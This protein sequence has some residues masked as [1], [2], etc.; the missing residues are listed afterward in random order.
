MQTE[1]IGKWISL[2]Y[3]QSQVYIGRELKPL[4]LTPS[5]YIYLIHLGARTGETNQKQLSDLIVIDGALTTRAMK[6]L[7][8]KG[9]IQRTRSMAD[10]R[11][12][13]I[14]LTDQG[15]AVLPAIEKNAARL[16]GD[17]RGRPGRAGTQ[18]NGRNADDDV[19]K[20]IESNKRS[21]Q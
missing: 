21:V 5:E 12:I 1:S 10:Q 13:M 8:R 16:D 6:S 20:R 15:R 18:P 2:L 3:R 19:Q 11:S 7:E 9:F 14:R 4:N 17:P